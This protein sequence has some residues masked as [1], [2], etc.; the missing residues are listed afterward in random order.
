V[1][2]F[3]T[4]SAVMPTVKT[5]AI[6]KLTGTDT[7]PAST[8]VGASQSTIVL[9]YCWMLSFA[10]P[11]MMLP[12]SPSHSTTYTRPSSTGRRVST[13]IARNSAE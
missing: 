4:A 6:T 9:T 3:C 5:P 10:V 12:S 7:D 13:L 11:D 1:R 2:S 8:S